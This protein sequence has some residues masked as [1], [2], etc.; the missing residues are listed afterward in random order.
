MV[1][2]TNGQAAA[3]IRAVTVAGLRVPGDVRIVG[4]DAGT[5]QNFGQITLT[6]AQ[7]PIDT[8]AHRAIADVLDPAAAHDVAARFPMPV[9]LDRGESCGCR[10]HHDPPLPT[11]L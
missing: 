10:P 6:S 4:F 3:T 9:T 5:T 2:G 7:Q 1:V 11:A 8:I